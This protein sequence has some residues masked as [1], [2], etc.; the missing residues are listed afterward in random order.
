MTTGITD[1]FNEVKTEMALAFVTPDYYQ[2]INPWRIEENDHKLL[3]RG[4]GLRF[5]PGENEESLGT[6]IMVQRRRLFVM[7]TLMSRHS[8]RD[9]LLRENTEKS[10]ME[11]A[12][13]AQKLLLS[14]KN[15]SVQGL[16]YEG[17]GGIQFVFD[18]K[19]SYLYVTS[20]F[21]YL[22]ET[23]TGYC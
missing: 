23:E 1:F 7:N 17:D 12:L 18:D 14:K 4:W 16:R 3:K 15:W 8:E 5:G 9:I 13:V 21:S 20:E 11:D 10:V 22:F 6:N 19:F 2:L